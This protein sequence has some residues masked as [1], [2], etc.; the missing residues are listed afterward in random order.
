MRQ[1]E[2]V[3][4]AKRRTVRVRGNSRR[5]GVRRAII[6]EVVIAVRVV[7]TVIEIILTDKCNYL[8]MCY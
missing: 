2:L 7:V 1:D 8:C 3:L 4:T 6:A 5:S